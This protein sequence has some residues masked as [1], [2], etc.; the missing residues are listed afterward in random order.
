[1]KRLLPGGLATLG[2]AMIGCQSPTS[3]SS[4]APAPEEPAKPTNVVQNPINTGAGESFLYPASGPRVPLWR[5]EWERARLEPLPKTEAD[6]EDQFL[7]NLESVRG[8]IRQKGE[9]S[10]RFSSATGVVNQREET[11]LLSGNVRLVSTRYQAT[12]I[13]DRAEYRGKT[14]TIVVSG[15]VQ[16]TTPDGRMNLGER[17]RANADLTELESIP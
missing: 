15:N 7:S 11:L 5:V 6:T 10:V 4:R 8:E 3:N 1:M 14:G 12:L 13:C 9:I 16:V 2:L 17:V